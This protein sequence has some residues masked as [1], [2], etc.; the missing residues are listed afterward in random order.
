M[1]NSDQNHSINFSVEER[2]LLAFQ[3]IQLENYKDAYKLLLQLI[4]DNSGY[5]F[6]TLGSFYE[7]GTVVPLDKI[8]ACSYYQRAVNENYISAF[9]RLGSILF[10]TGDIAYARSVFESGAK[11]GSLP[12]MYQ[13]GVMMIEG[14]GGDVDQ[15]QGRQWL[16]KAAQEGH[17][18][19]QRR[20]IGLE[21]RESK[22]IISKI[23]SASKILGLIG[24]ALKEYIKD[25]DSE[26]LK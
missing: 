13:L 20:I 3:A 26:K 17:I 23:M 8:A 10:D 5:A 24:P 7:T 22:S 15:S 9:S 19:S 2:E 4:D 18:F 11:L 1:K 12:C 21:V 6:N 16:K 14:Q 25:S